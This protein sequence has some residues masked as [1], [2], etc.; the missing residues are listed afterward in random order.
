MKLTMCVIAM[1]CCAFANAASRVQSTGCDVYVAGIAVYRGHTAAQASVVSQRISEVLGYGAA[2]A[3]VAVSGN[4]P[5]FTVKVMGQPIASFEGHTAKASAQVLAVRL[6][7]AMAIPAVKIASPGMIVPLGSTRYIAVS[8]YS[9][10][11]CEVLV[12]Q[13][14]VSPFIDVK[15]DPIAKKL[16][17]TGIATGDTYVSVSGADGGDSIAIKVKPWAGHVSCGG[18][19]SVTGPYVKASIVRK[20]VVSA[21]YR[22]SSRLPESSMNVDYL[23]PQNTGL[24]EGHSLSATAKVTITSPNALPV[25]YKVSVPVNN[26]RVY[27]S[28][29][30]ILRVSNNPETVKR[31]GTLFEGSVIPGKS[32]RLLYHH[33]NSTGMT[34]WIN[35]ELVN[36]SDQACTLQVFG[37]YPVSHIDPLQLGAIAGRDFLSKLYSR[38]GMLVNIQANSK[39]SLFTQRVPARWSS[40]GVIQMSMDR[41]Q[42]T[43]CGLK[44]SLDSVKPSLAASELL[45]ASYPQELSESER[46]VR[47]KDSIYETSSKTIKATYEVGKSWQFIR[48]G[49]HA[50][51]DKHGNKLYG[52]YGVIYSVDL[53]ISNPSNVAKKVRL[54]VEPSGGLADAAIAIG[55]DIV[56]LGVLQP[57]RDYTVRTILLQPG[58]R[59]ELRLHT[60]PLAGSNYPVTLVVS[61]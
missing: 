18:A 61:S 53:T 46:S 48:I 4:R 58:E 7:K 34:G 55:S 15:Y 27:P 38:Q 20:A 56:Q 26:V 41:N 23:A 5:R 49:E 40:S 54:A 6:K 45:G 10:A 1:L 19:V 47:E 33:L 9:A 30:T 44:V 2:P 36:P 35:I 43:P 3:N 37:A 57:N 12:K 11:D 50:V 31:M 14:D 16:K 59:K 8:G 29:E 51:V 13:S 39:I 42:S 21:F 28:D 25:S 60:M 52:N 24:R 22:H 17:L 32:T